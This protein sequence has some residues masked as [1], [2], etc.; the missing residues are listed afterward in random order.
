MESVP[1]RTPSCYH[2]ARWIVVAHGAAGNRGALAIE[3]DQRVVGELFTNPNA[4]TFAEG[5]L[6]FE[7]GYT[8][9]ASGIYHAPRDV[10]VSVVGRYQD[11]QNFARLVIA[12]DLAQ[13]PEAI[14]AYPN[15]E[16]RF[17]YTLTVDA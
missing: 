15:G 9:K 2:S 16:S 7:R 13:G 11:G 10:T 3:N 8:I 6:F 12:P 4:E 14:R 5:R 17:T 1:D